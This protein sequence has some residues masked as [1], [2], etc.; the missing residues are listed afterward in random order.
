M[1][2]LAGAGRDV[3]G[4]QS[5]IQEIVDLAIG[6]IFRLPF[7][8]PR[9]PLAATTVRISELPPIANDDAASVAEG[10]S[11]LIDLIANDTDPE[12]ALDPSS[13]EI[14]SA[15]NN[16][17]L[18]LQGDGTVLYTHDGSETTADAFQYRIF[19]ATGR[20]S[21]TAIVSIG[22]DPVNDAPFARTHVFS[23]TEDTPMTIVSSNGVLIG[24]TDAEGS[25]LTANLVSP[26]SS[27]ASFTLRADGSFDYTPGADFAGSDVFYYSVSDGE[28]SSEVTA[29][30]VDVVPVNDAPVLMKNLG[31]TVSGTGGRIDASMLD[32]ED[33]D[34]SADEV[35]YEIRTTPSAGHLY[36]S[37]DPSVPITRFSQ[38]ELDAGLVMYSLDDASASSDTFGFELT[39]TA[40]AR[41]AEAEFAVAVTPVSTIPS[42]DPDDLAT[43]PD[44]GDDPGDSDSPIGDPGDAPDDTEDSFGSDD[45]PENED[46]PGDIGP[47]PFDEVYVETRIRFVLPDRG[48]D[49]RRDTDVSGAAARDDDRRDGSSSALS[50]IDPV[51]RLLSVEQQIA[52]I[53]EAMRS[54][55]GDRAG[56]LESEVSIWV[57]RTDSL[58]MALGLG[59]V[60]QILRSG[61]LLAVSA[62]SVPLWRGFDPVA[63]LGVSDDSR[64]RRAD[65]I[66]YAERMED[67]TSDVGR[68]LDTRGEGPGE[69]S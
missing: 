62:A 1:V 34:N 23:A 9:R 57:G 69:R 40:G 46:T 3:E 17:S 15:P 48:I 51:M 50:P 10:G 24:A 20:I 28:G 41:L 30:T 5:L 52:D 49:D 63:V 4:R 42:F 56:Q 54:D 18:A 11:V 22:I 37:N 53:L 16:G 39:D 35:V 25:L 2:G 61:S 27:A 26:P 66:R 67:E 59:L 31:T 13:I 44:P 32:A 14:V 6:R 8:R 58:V 29:V 47:G 65:E 21:G 43:T 64:R 36:L 19:D 12:G 68:V 38:A 33:V 7:G 60:A 45:D 55:L